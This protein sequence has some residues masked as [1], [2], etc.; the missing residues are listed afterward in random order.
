LVG[1]A[2]AGIYHLVWLQESKQV[3]MANA[4]HDI[5]TVCGE[6]ALSAFLL[7]ALFSLPYVRRQLF[8]VFRWA[9]IIFVP[10]FIGFL[11]FHYGGGGFLGW[12]AVALVLYA[13]DLLYRLYSVLFSSK[14]RTAI[15]SAKKVSNDVVKWME[16]SP[17]LLDSTSL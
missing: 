6:V 1:L 8:E 15:V 10:A 12:A 2:H 17:T 7:I 3:W 4:V 14:S 5:P 16:D 13:G 11:L 9:H